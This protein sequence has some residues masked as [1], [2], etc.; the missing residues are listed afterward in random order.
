VTAVSLLVLV[1]DDDPLM[2][3]AIRLALEQDG[4]LVVEAS[5]ALAAV[6]MLRERDFDAALIDWE[7]GTSM[8]GAEVARKCPA[9][10]ARI[11]VTGHSTEE[12]RAAWQDPL[13]G[14]LAFVR[15]GGDMF[16]HPTNGLKVILE[17]VERALTLTP[18]RGTKRP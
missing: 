6:A 4:H 8:T 3:M 13:S 1:V 9:G 16:T 17:R 11:M 2:R 10:C 7:L 14:L 12:I 18:P 15:K 5:S